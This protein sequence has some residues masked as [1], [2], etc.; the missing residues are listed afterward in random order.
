MIII[1][2]VIGEECEPSLSVGVVK[3]GAEAGYCIVMDAD[4]DTVQPQD[5][6]VIDAGNYLH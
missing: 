2:T 6:H 5:T 1:K 4:I 3:E